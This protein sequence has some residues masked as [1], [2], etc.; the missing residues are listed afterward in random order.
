LNPQLFAA[1]DRGGRS[2]GRVLPLTSR[3]CS[4]RFSI[5]P[6]ASGPPAHDDGWPRLARPL[7]GR[8]AA[9][10]DTR[11]QMAAPSHW[12][13][14]RKPRP[15]NRDLGARRAKGEA[16]YTITTPENTCCFRPLR[17]SGRTAPLCEGWQQETPALPPRVSHYEHVPPPPFT[18]LRLLTGEVANPGHRNSFGALRPCTLG[19]SSG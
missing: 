14:W 6:A 4:V 18:L 2:S 10:D 17:S 11:F 7:R 12:V 15:V 13:A 5:P 1:A 19:G 16:I 9:R 3:K 8:T